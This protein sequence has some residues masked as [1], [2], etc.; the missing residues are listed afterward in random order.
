MHP[1]ETARFSLS[2]ARLGMAETLTPLAAR[3]ST[4]LKSEDSKTSCAEAIAEKAASEATKEDFIPCGTVS[5]D[6]VGKESVFK[7]E[8][9]PQVTVMTLNNHL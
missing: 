3:A 9:V 6:R 7:T 8:E 4:T 2:P 1:V 5:Y